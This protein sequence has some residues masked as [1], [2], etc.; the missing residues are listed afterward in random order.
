MATYTTNY[1][2]DKYEG[3]D[4]PNLT[5][6]YNSAMDKIDAQMTWRASHTTVG[7]SWTRACPCPS[8]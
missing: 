7:T 8:D 6:Q 4:S 5:D 3:A 1:N 2:L